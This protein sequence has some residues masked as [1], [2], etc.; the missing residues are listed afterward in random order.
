[1]KS[2]KNPVNTA[3]TSS[4]ETI[5]VIEDNLLNL[6]MA[7]ELLEAAGFRTF[8]AEDAL[9]GIKIAK[10]IV[11]DLI[12]MDLHLPYTDGFMATQMIKA[13]PLLTN[14]PI[15]AFTALA[16]RE[17]Q[18]RA[19]TAG[20]SGVISKPIDINKFASTVA[21]YLPKRE[22]PAEEEGDLPEESRNRQSAGKTA[23]AKSTPPS[24]Y[25]MDFTSPPISEILETTGMES[26][27]VDS[28]DV[29]SHRILVVDDNPMNVEL[30]KD[31]LESMGQEAIPAYGGQE[32]I[33]L[34][35]ETWPALIL[36]DIMMPDVDGYAVMENLKKD[37]RTASIPV[38]FISALN[39]TQD[40]VRGFKEGTYD[41]ITKPFKIEEVKARIL[42]SLRIKDLQDSLRSE[43]DKLNA[44]FQFSRDAIALLGSDFTVVSANP[45][46][47]AWFGLQLSPD[48]QPEKPA[49][50]MQLIG[51]QC[52]YGNPCPYH[53]SNIRLGEEEEEE[54]SKLPKKEEESV[55]LESAIVANGNGKTRHLSIQSGRVPGLDHQ[56]QSGFVVVLRDVTKE[57]LIEQSKQTFVATLTHDLKTPIR[58][59]FQALDLLRTGSFGPLNQEQQEMLKEIIQ[60]N[61]Y[62]SRLVESLLTTYM[63]EE[64]K[65]ELRLE[66]VDLNRMIREEVAA[67]LRTLASEKGQHLEVKLDESLPPV[68]MDR[69]EI[70]RVLNNLV[71]NAITFTPNDGKITLA[72]EFKEHRAWVSV[73]DTG[74]GIEP[75]NLA[76]LFD[77][78]KTMAKKFQQVGT[79]LGL[80]LSRMIV[81][82]HGGHIGVESE[83]GKGS[84]F[85]FSLPLAKVDP[86]GQSETLPKGR[87]QSGNEILA[88]SPS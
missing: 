10:E 87:E 6:D 60:S 51:C 32:A 63:Y 21:S 88:K 61:R 7:C 84:R 1:M 30:L 34:V 44:I 68:R 2:K 73:T 45:L 4:K 86:Q 48:G 39:K 17:D 66:P 55:I 22:L 40:M 33:R 62:M 35:R 12:L 47:A 42:A 20:C 14:I 74:Q 50:F 49:N 46:F 70:Q 38:I 85:F 16:M 11:P 76:L 26:D 81:E 56:R 72:T 77:R 5:L 67:S 80:Y 25:P 83:L 23:E 9:T 18:E 37:P 52:A 28:A 69:I 58:A 41:Y 78:Y 8:H 31:A 15:V 27:Q 54:D 79:G 57:K 3:R 36:L 65:M 24:I 75:Q 53:T 13:D 29:A 64:G 43:R 71:Q 82:A 19:L 59:E